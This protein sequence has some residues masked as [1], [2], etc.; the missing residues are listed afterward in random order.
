MFFSSPSLDS[1]KANTCVH[2]LSGCLA[3]TKLEPTGCCLWAKAWT[4][5]LD[6]PVLALL[7]RENSSGFQH[8]VVP[9][10]HGSRIG[11]L[12]VKTVRPLAMGPP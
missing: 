11:E 6:Q 2:G 12:E 5:A 4:E 1:V 10:G 7:W 3:Q 9:I 8:W